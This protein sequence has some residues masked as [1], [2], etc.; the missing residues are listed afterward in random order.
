MPPNLPPLILLFRSDP[1]SKQSH[2]HPSNFAP[3]FLLLCPKGRES[4]Q[5]VGRTKASLEPLAA[6]HGSVQFGAQRPRSVPCRDLLSR[7]INSRLHGWVW[8]S[9]GQNLDTLVESLFSDES[10]G[11]SLCPYCSEVSPMARN[12]KREKTKGYKE[13]LRNQLQRGR[14]IVPL[15]CLFSP[16]SEVGSLQ[17]HRLNQNQTKTT[18]TN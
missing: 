5:G 1:P 6:Q 11:D 8:T 4:S 10:L 14:V 9:A 12:A 16:P 13:R 17:S 2:F 15:L 3:C 7:G 18:P